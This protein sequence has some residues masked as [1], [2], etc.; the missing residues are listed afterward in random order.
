MTVQQLIQR[1][2]QK[3]QQ[4]YQAHLSK[5]EEKIFAKFDRTLFSEN[6]QNVSFYLK[7]INQTLDRIKTLESNDSNHYNFLAE[8]LLAQCSV[9][10]EALVRKN[11]HLTE[12][13]TTTKQTIQ[14]SQHSIHKLPPRERL[15]KYYE[16]REQLNNLYRQH[17]DLAQ[18][19]KNNDEKIR[20]AQLAEVYKKRQQKCQDAIDL[21][22]EY[23]VFKEEVENRE[24]TE[25]K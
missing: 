23:L 22:E 21:L 20:Y 11:T 1:L 8:R 5:R 14:K 3:V 24:N 15:E 19:E 13:Q 16:A 6:G 9:L 12:S 10:S 4:L 18:A 7:E 25:N 2:D 17:K